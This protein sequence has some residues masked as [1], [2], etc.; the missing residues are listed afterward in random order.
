MNRS[1]A[2]APIP[3][4]P[5]TVRNITKNAQPTSAQ[6]TPR[7]LTEQQRP[8]RRD[9]DVPEGVQARSFQLNTHCCR[10]K[11]RSRRSITCCAL[12][13]VLCSKSCE[14]SAR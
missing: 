2:K 9:R 5:A 1:T 11:R 7:S 3:Y 4:R 6:A 13:T 14:D 8:A 10:G 12:L